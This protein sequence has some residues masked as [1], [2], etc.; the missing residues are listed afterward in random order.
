[1][2]D[3]LTKSTLPN[4]VVVLT[5]DLPDEKMNLLGER[6]MTELN[7]RLDEI[8]RDSGVKGLVIISGKADNFIAGADVKIIKALQ[9]QPSQ[10]AYEASKQGKQVLNRLA[11]LP[12]NT[13]AAIHG[14]CLGGGTELA[15]ACK[16]RI[17]SNSS[18]TKIGLPEVMLGFVPGWD[19]TIRLPKLIGIQEGLKIITAGGVVDA[20]K[21]W[22][23]GLFDEIVDREKLAD[24]A[25]EVATTGNVNRFSKPLTKQ[26]ELFALEGNPLGR[27]VLKSQ[28]LPMVKRKSKG[29]VAPLEAA[30][31]VFNGF[32]MPMDEASDQ[33]SQAFAKLAVT[34]ISKN[35][36][37][38]FFAQSESKKLPDGAES[39][40]ESG[41]KVE[42]VGVLGAG[43][44]GAG[45]AQA[46]AYSGY[47]VV[48]KDIKQEFVDKGMGTIKGLFDSLVEKKKMDSAEAAKLVAAIKPTIDYADMA[49]CDLVIEAVLEVMSV[50]Q[51]S[52]AELEKVITKP[53]I[54]A[55]NTSSLSVTEIGSVSKNPAGIVGL[56][57]FNPVHKM[58]LVEVVRTNKTSDETASAAQSF[59]LK[60]GKTTVTTSDAAGFVVNRILA[61]YLREAI[62]LMEQ[63]VPMDDVEKAMKNF[64]MPMGPYELLDEVGLDISEKVIHVIHDALGDRMAAPAIMKN[65]EE[66]K[67]T[68]RKG[69]KGIYLY[70]ADGRRQFVEEKKGKGLFPQKVKKYTFNPDV[71]AAI[72]APRKPKTEGEIQ[73]RLV[74]VMVNEAVRV[75]EENIVAEPSQLD[76]AMVYGTGFPPFRG[77]VIRYADQLGLQVVLQKLEFL[78]SLCGENYRPAPLL[79]A[80][81]GKGENFYTE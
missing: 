24:R 64:G 11:A 43:V 41:I 14:A 37:G 12:F 28:A 59:A 46:A 30:K 29:Y 34:S 25:Q 10:K 74:L 66:L 40:V 61:P 71:L 62:L 20:R 39:G 80:K 15:L 16:F 8:T 81:A 21:A 54:F 23:L 27:A 17:G 52:L 19:G 79:V 42:K 76:L 7:T 33:E 9:N 5:I 65:I 32:E 50:K 57:F 75:L 77:G 6:L 3:S 18:K 44:M 35:L 51:G 4:G 1:M 36:V 67:I 68:G 45:I 38:I 56:H 69:G 53:F 55:S 2:A 47:Q 13:V 48:L 22:K 60:L 31:A 63:G 58:P 72:K 78:S 26:V 73:D 70:G 49:D